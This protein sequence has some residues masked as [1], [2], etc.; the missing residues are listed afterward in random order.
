MVRKMTR[1]SHAKRELIRSFP[2]S[3]VCCITCAVSL[4]GQPAS[5]STKPVAKAPSYDVVSIRPHKDNGNGS[6]WWHPTVNGYEAVNTEPFLLILEAYDIKFYNQLLGLPRWAT[7]EQFD[8]EARIDEDSLP[9]YRKLSERERKQQAAPM[10][11]S[12][13]EDRFQL[14]VHHETRVLPVYELVVAKAGFKLKQAHAPENLYGM[15]TDKGRI[16]IRA[17]PIGSRFIVGLTMASGR[18]VIDKTGLA[19]YY[20]IDL[21]W[22]TDEDLAAGVTGPSL[23]TALEEQLGLKLV[24]A[25]APVDVIV[26]DHIAPPSP[27]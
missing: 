8:I 14:K 1:H 13:L 20:D 23:F 10:L 12:M 17:G 27:N 26:I 18:I 2:I 19:G 11:R 24:P 5:L 7:N 9:A 3:L 4:A 21:N 22:T 6:R 25:R 15:L 16:K